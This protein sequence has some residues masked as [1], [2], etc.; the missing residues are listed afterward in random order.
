M[1]SA[2]RVTKS[3]KKMIKGKYYYLYGAKDQRI[4]SKL[5]NRLA[6]IYKSVYTY[7]ILMMAKAK[8]GRGRGIDCSGFVS[9]AIWSKLVRESLIILSN[10]VT[11]FGTSFT[12]HWVSSTHLQSVVLPLVLLNR[13]TFERSRTKD[14]PSISKVKMT[15]IV[16]LCTSSPVTS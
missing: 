10:S 8:I 3:A 4:T 9:K 6:S 2:K 12:L 11:F 13:S 7:S 14:V 1:K 16:M 15:L 5:V